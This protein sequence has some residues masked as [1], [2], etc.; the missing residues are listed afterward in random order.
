MR[1]GIPFWVAAVVGVGLLTVPL[2]A[3]VSATT[4]PTVL[5]PAVRTVPRPSV[6]TKGFV[7][8]RVF[9]SPSGR[10]KCRL[11]RS[12][13]ENG[14]PYFVECLVTDS[15]MLVKFGFGKR[16]TV[17]CAAPNTHLDCPIM[18]GRVSTRTATSRDRAL[19]AGARTVPYGRLIQLD[20]SSD[21]G[22]YYP[23]CTVSPQ[24][25]TGCF[26][27]FDDGENIE[28]WITGSGR[29]TSC[30]GFALVDYPLPTGYDRCRL[31]RSGR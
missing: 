26:T 17:P 22:G 29:L 10:V 28:L 9:S 4:A 2:P 6:P 16:R 14:R 30:P 12:S 21:T 13:P 20:A 23:F 25:G 3:A 19:F 11:L 7:K 27:G 8:A 31:L 15:G 18:F 1:R 5:A 24:F